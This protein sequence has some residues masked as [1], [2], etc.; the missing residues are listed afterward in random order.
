M[1]LV[2]QDPGLGQDVEI[3]VRVTGG[4]LLVAFRPI[5]NDAGEG[6]HTCANFGS[7][8]EWRKC[9]LCYQAGGGDSGQ[10]LNGLV[11]ARPGII[12]TSMPQHD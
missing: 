9:S 8:A 1:E 10:E 3:P 12:A 6:F 4:S 2:P 5:A 7:P 11:L